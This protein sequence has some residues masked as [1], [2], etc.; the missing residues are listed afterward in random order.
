MQS[1]S[2][3]SQLYNSAEV[4]QCIAKHFT[5]DC[6]NDIKHDLFELLINLPTGCLE[7]KQSKGKLKAYVAVIIMNLKRQR[8]GKVAK[9]VNN[10]TQYDELPTISIL[11]TV[12]NEDLIERLQNEVERKLNWYQKGMVELYARLGSI[13]AVSRATK[14]PVESIKYTIKESRKIIKKAW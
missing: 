14:I 9:M 13:R 12:E 7:E 6:A 3:I 5:Q 10:Y 11:E 1:D 2:I 8:Y 4:D